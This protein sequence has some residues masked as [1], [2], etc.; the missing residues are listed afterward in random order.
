MLLSIFFLR[1]AQAADVAYGAYGLFPVGSTRGL[2]MG[3]A[4]VGLADD[5][6][7]VLLN[8][9]GLSSAK[10]VVDYSSAE[11]RVVNREV[12]FGPNT[13]DRTGIPY[14]SRFQAAALRWGFLG[15]GLG[16]SSPYDLNYDFGGQET[17]HEILHVQSYD[18]GASL[19][20]FNMFSVGATAHLEKVRVAY[21]NSS[22]QQIESVAQGV[23][24]TVGV[25]MPLGDHATAGVTYSPERRYNIDE[26]LDSQI[27]A[28]GSFSEWFH[29]VVIPAKVSLGLHIHSTSRLRLVGDIDI[30]Q[31]VKNGI[32]VGGS[33]ND[34]SDKILEEA[35]TV[36]HGGFELVV[37]KTENFDFTWRGGGYHEPKRLAFA[38][39]RFHF[40]M[41]VEARFHFLVVAASYDQAPD[42]SNVTQSIGISLGKIL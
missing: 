32:Y 25:L 17:T 9:A 36:L 13:T 23:Y 20:F 12:F 2:A 27:T 5:A 4:F 39:D 7:A 26:S 31:A 28:G 6:S 29:D 15:I 42:F 24:P 33:K 14:T 8:P 3:G 1:S 37:A 35:Q 11:D 30:Y 19:R 16:V 34:P 10:Y 38:E 21:Q 18:L 41:G 22:G 40:T